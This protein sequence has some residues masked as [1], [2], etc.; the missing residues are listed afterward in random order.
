MIK[1]VFTYNNYLFE[2]LKKNYKL[3]FQILDLEF[4]DIIKNVIV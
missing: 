1:I 2:G 3:A 4:S